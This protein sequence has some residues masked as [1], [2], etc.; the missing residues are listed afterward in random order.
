MDRHKA[1]HLN[2]DYPRLL[3]GFVNHPEVQIKWE[4]APAVRYKS[5]IEFLG[6]LALQNL[7]DS[8]VQDFQT[9]SATGEILG[10]PR[11]YDIEDLVAASKRW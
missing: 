5:A 11:G 2:H 3:A 4:T 1:A 6:L 9:R 7:R 10:M 8:T